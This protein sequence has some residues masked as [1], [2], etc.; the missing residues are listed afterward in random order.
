MLGSIEK[1]KYADL[2]VLGGDF[3]AVPDD[4]IGTL[5]PDLTIVGGRVVFEASPR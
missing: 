4:R 3:L 1:G 2:V 5:E